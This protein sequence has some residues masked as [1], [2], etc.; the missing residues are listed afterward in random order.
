MSLIALPVFH[1]AIAP[2]VHFGTLRSGYVA[3]IMRR[4]D[5]GPYLDFIGKYN[6]TD[7]IVVPPI[8]ISI[9]LCN[10]PAKKTSLKKI[11][12]IVCGAAPL[13]KEIQ[14][15]FQKLLADGVPLT[16]GWGMTETCCASAI[17]PYPE[18]ANTG[19]V[20]RLIPNVEAKYAFPMSQAEV[21]PL[22]VN[23]YTSQQSAKA[24]NRLI[25]D[26]GSTISTPDTHGELYIRGPTV[27]PGYFNNP[28]ANASIF[29]SDKW[30]RTGDIARCDFATL[31]WYIVGRKKELIKVRGFQVAPSELEAVLLSH[32]EIADAA[33]VG[34]PIPA[35]GTQVPRAFVVRRSGSDVSSAEVI[36][37]A[38]KRLA[39]YKRLSGGVRFVNA[40][41]RNASGKILRRALGRTG[42]H[43]MSCSPK[44]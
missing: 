30:L 17:F 13:D 39:E 20:G 26:N 10:L 24:E 41:P 36:E 14:S 11:K 34:V 6:I 16:Q 38:A 12:S 7:L 21:L 42:G 15:R 4:F 28:E 8:L 18:N 43:G 1:A 37:Y 31:K 27:T 19:S 33:V 22:S 5:L 29:T 32:P 25:D 35:A 3:Y 40:I 23:I 2:L 44:L 9:L